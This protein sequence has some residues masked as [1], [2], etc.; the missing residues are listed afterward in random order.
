MELTRLGRFINNN[1]IYINAGVFGFISHILFNYLGV[2]HDNEGVEYYAEV[3]TTRWNAYIHTIGMPFT[4]YGMLLWIPALLCK[5]SYD[6]NRLQ[7][8]LYIMYMCHYLIINVYITLG[9]MLMYITPLIL[10]IEKVY[11]NY[12]RKYLFTYGFSISFIALV[13][14]EIAGHY[15]GGDEPSRL[16]A[17]PNAIIY[18]I[19]FSFSHMIE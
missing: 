17:I 2:L 18:A 11:G 3:H 1:Q 7:R 16:E 5:S 19:Y 10:S 6:A 4:I 9:I 8:S 13:F 15:Y 14:Q 12:D